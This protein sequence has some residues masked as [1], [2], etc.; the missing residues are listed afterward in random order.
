[1]RARHGSL[2]EGAAGTRAAGPRRGSAGGVL[3]RRRAARA[4]EARQRW[5]EDVQW[6]RTLAPALGRPV[7]PEENSSRSTALHVASPSGEAGSGA[8]RS[9]WVH[10]VED[11]RSPSIRARRSG[12]SASPDRAR[13]PTATSGRIDLPRTGSGSGEDIT[14][15]SGEGR[16]LRGRMQLVF[17]IIASVNPRMS[18]LKLIAEPLVVHG[19]VKSE[20]A[21]RDKSSPCSSGAGRRG[22]GRTTSPRLLR[23]ATPTHRHRPSMAL[24]GDFIVADEPV[25]ALDVSVRALRQPLRDLQQRVG[26]NSSPPT[27]SLSSPH[28]PPHRHPLRRQLLE[29]ADSDASQVAAA[30]LHGGLLSSFRPRTRRCSVC[31]SVRPARRDPQPDRPAAGP[32]VPGPAPRPGNLPAGDPAVR[33]E[34]A[35]SLGLPA[36]ALTPNRWRGFNTTSVDTSERAAEFD[37]P[38]SWYVSACS[39]VSSPAC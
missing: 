14:T 25:S 10:A 17:D 37:G 28:L 1:M 38:R 27:T 29:L 8:S 21:A 18:V 24:Q 34:G 39:L 13:L 20:A 12:S 23:R 36:R 33:G 31:A 7:P 16:R 2:P 22:H 26:C 5:I 19:Q 32:P 11:C 6:P 9:T 4:A 35:R 30:P 15:T 3:P